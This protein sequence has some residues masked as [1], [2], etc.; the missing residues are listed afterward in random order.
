MRARRAAACLA[1]L[2]WAWSSL[3]GTAPAAA[4]ETLALGAAIGPAVGDQLGH[5]V[6]GL[7]DVSGDGRPDVAIGL[8]R[9]NGDGSDRG[10]VWLWGADYPLSGPPNKVLQ[11]ELA[12]DQFGWAVRPAGDVN[13]DGDD[14]FIVGA[15]YND[16]AGANA[17]RAYVFFGG[18][19]LD[20]QPDVVLTGE[21]AGDQ[22]GYAVAGGGDL[23]A[24]G[25]DDVLV[26]AP[27][28]AAGGSTAGRAYVFFGGAA[29]D[30]QADAV[31]TGAAGAA[32]GWALGA[33]G[34]WNGDGHAD[35]VVGAILTRFAYVHF[36]GPAFDG[37]AD[38]VLAGE[39]NADRFGYAFATLPDF[40][41]DGWNDLA[42]GAI[43]NDAGGFDAGRV[44]LYRGGPGLDA[45]PDYVF[46]GVGYRILF[47]RG[48][49]AADVDGDGH[50]DLLVGAP[51]P[52]TGGFGPGWVS[53]FLG[54]DAAGPRPPD[55][56][57][58][59]SLVGQQ[60]SA[61]FGC[62]LSGAGDRDGDGR[63]EFLVGEN[64]YDAPGLLDAGRAWHYAVPNA[65][66]VAR[67]DTVLTAED[68]PAVAAV[69]A[70]DEDPDG[71]LAPSSLVVVRGPAAGAAAVD[72]LAGTIGYV[73]GPDWAGTDSL[74]YAVRDAEG[75]WSDTTEVT[76]LVTPVNDAPLAAADADT[77]VQDAPVAVP[78]LANDHD[79]DDGLRPAALAVVLAP[80]NGTATADTTAG[81]ILYAPAPGFAG[82]DTLAYVVSDF[83]GATSDTTPVVV[84]VLDVTPP[85]AISGLA[86]AA[87]DGTVTVAWLAVPPD[88]T[89]I[90]VWRAAWR[91]SLGASAYPLYND[92]PGAALPARP[93]GRD[94]AAA[95]GIWTRVAVLPA[96]ATAC[97]D[98]V[99]TRGVWFYEAFARDAAG[100]W[101]P[102]ADDNA[103][104]RNYRL[105]DL[106]TPADG[107]VDGGDV[108]RLAQSYGLA[109]GD[110]LFDPTAD[111]GPTDDRSPAGQPATDGRVDFEDVMIAAVDFDPPFAAGPPGPP[112]DPT[113]LAWVRVDE[114]TWSLRLETPSPRLKGLC[115]SETLPESLT[116][117]VAPGALLAQQPVPVFLQNARA[118]RL[119]VSLAVLG[120]GFGFAGAGELCRVTLSAPFELPDPALVARDLDNAPL[121]SPLLHATDVPAAAVGAALAQNAPNPFN[122]ATTIRFT[123]PRAQRAR[124]D[125]HDLA[126]RRL[127]TLVDAELE[128][129]EHAVTWRGLDARG[130]SLP[131]GVYVCRLRAGSTDLTRR[132]TLLR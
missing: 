66:P 105:G 19:E 57:A 35:A 2:A 109:R 122:P 23:N 118:T 32:L 83:A 4:A 63:E 116:V 124:V 103:H 72:T 5:A 89:E 60:E 126:G 6:A 53:V 127:A 14:D 90:E 21:A 43:H 34:D 102:P 8:P 123:L 71:L 62:Q 75:A 107:V 94:A 110:T 120:R 61:R 15:P 108:A 20:L 47:G 80:A 40:D 38:L 25:F 78:V 95:G 9:R 101:S 28:N 84:A 79:V 11:G 85:R 81:T 37:V 131:S 86:A 33:G 97:P 17:G 27:Y 39:Q 29:P 52:D 70:N 125:V 46:T 113:P 55:T 45:T 73:P 68:T 10:E 67:A 128:A 65:R 98:T 30:A 31:M 115:L 44:Y 117:S 36:G 96:T 22:F 129:G 77:T 121:A 119:E 18:A 112:S 69:L 91:D 130:R 48:L 88:A 74:A 56:E 3:S 92:A 111:I 51:T 49:G 58:D 100:L 64:L 50:T 99:A 132:M 87:G 106:G 13:G 54:G 1:A 76:I 16:A 104:A 82:L 7:G 41:G 114:R 12:G 42:V 59:V 26:G 24:D 93:A